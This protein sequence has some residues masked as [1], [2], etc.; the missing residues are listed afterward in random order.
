VVAISG[1]TALQGLRDHGKVHPGQ[2]VLIIGAR[3]A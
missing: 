2:K 1:L 3:V